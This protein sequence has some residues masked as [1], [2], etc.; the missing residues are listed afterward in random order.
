MFYEIVLNALKIEE[1]KVG[2]KGGKRNDLNSELT[3]M[4]RLI[5]LENCTK[6]G[7]KPLKYKITND[8]CWSWRREKRLKPV[9]TNIKS[10]Y[11]MNMLPLRFLWS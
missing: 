6:I 5:K 1:G 9:D 4:K 10:M 2:V 8:M 3:P 11:A 7:R